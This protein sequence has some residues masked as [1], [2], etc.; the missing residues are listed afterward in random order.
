ML[1]IKI[2]LVLAKTDS[3]GCRFEKFA[4]WGEP[5]GGA[6][7]SNYHVQAYDQQAP[8]FQYA[9]KLTPHS[10]AT[11]RSW[12]VRPEYWGQ[13]DL[14]FAPRHKSEPR[15]LVPGAVIEAG[16]FLTFA[17]TYINVYC[18]LR[19]LR[20]PPKPSVTALCIL[21]KMLRDLNEGDANPAL[22]THLTFVRAG[23]FLLRS[24]MDA[25]SKF[26][27]GKALEHI[28]KL[29]Q[30]GGRFKGDKSHGVF[31]GFRL[32]AGSFS[33]ESPVP[34]PKRFGKAE[35]K[36]SVQ[37]DGPKG[38]LT[39]EE[40]AAVGLAYRRTVDQM[41]KEN[42]ST[43]MSA[44]IGLTLSTT[45]MRAS[46]LQ[47][48]RRDALFEDPDQPGRLR[49]RVSRPKLDVDQ[50]LPVP[51]KLNE[52][53]QEQFDIVKNFSEEARE[54]FA[55]YTHQSPKSPAGISELFVPQRF[56]ELLANEHLN[57]RQVGKLMGLTSPDQRFGQR[58]VE[59]KKKCFVDLP[60][61]IFDCAS[62]W[63]KAVVPIREV[64]AIYKRHGVTLAIPPSAERAQLV[65]RVIVRKWGPKKPSLELVADL[66][67]LFESGLARQP[68]E[69]V[70]TNELKDWLLRQFKYQQKFPHWPYATKDRKVRLDEA[71]AVYY[72]A[73]RDSNVMAGDQ[74]AS[75]WLPMLVPIT[76]LN[77]WISGTSRYPPLLFM[78]T[79]VR[80]ENGKYPSISVHQTRKFFHTE[81]LL[82][83]A[84]RPLVDELAGRKTGWQGAHYD[85]RTPQ[86]I[87][88][89]SVETF[90]PESDFEVVGPVE[91]QAPP[92]ARIVERRTFL[93]ESA[94]PKHATEIGG[95]RTDWSMNPC[96]QFGDCMRCDAHVWRKGDARR[97]PV[98]RDLK[99]ES[100]RSIEIGKKKL[101]ASPQARSIEKQVR[102]LDETVK[103]CDEILALEADDR[104]TAGTLVT[105]DAAPTALSDAA[106]LSLLRADLT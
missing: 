90:D 33:F 100:L 4:R 10:H 101:L 24:S 26:D 102:Q 12:F 62:Q 71:L 64:E 72:A 9:A 18:E 28:S 75:W 41:G 29:I 38:S 17:K 83:G 11:I 81:A 70:A 95:C 106:R 32:I 84:S 16:P 105:F 31:P 89:Q 58:F 57:A 8:W 19:Q 51:K 21:E 34:A 69:F 30:S 35:K 86:Q 46:D 14:Y 36:A 79:N 92:R 66:D 2:P 42:T 67:A 3:I 98:I 82:A 44:L 97:L 37:K 52:I 99:A 47:S 93:L 55:F 61:D 40:V 96:P 49:L 15:V 25:S 7:F 5:G 68:E 65:H 39:G 54:A 27:V 103:R 56:R 77:R 53:A 63:S 60:G 80:L 23:Q 88:R 48:L 73:G 76:I 22:L 78:K 20:S 94:A 50:I 87:L 104:I 45:S 43:F 1:Q 74:V 13:R 6:G 59:L 85:Y 91:E